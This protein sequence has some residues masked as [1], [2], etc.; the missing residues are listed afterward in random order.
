MSN[1]DEIVMKEIDKNV[2][3]KMGVA[4]AELH[5]SVTKQVLLDL[6]LLTP[7]E[8]KVGGKVKKAEGLQHE[9]TPT[10]LE[11]IVARLPLLLVG[12]AGCGKTHIAV[13]CAKM[14]DLAFYSI[15]VNEQ[16]SKAD[17]LG[18]KDANGKMV[19]TN[20]REAY[21]HGGVFIIDEIDAGNPNILTVINS[22]LSNDMCPFSD[23]MVQKHEDFVCVC[24]ANTFGEGESMQYIGRNILDSAT[25]DR[26]ATIHI[27]YSGLLE[28]ALLP[29]YFGFIRELRE[30]FNKNNIQFVV[31]TRGGLRLERM[32]AQIE[33]KLSAQQVV[34]CMNLHQH[35]LRDQK[36]KEVIQKYV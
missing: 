15:S 8:I 2:G 35:I 30:Y 21:E 9:M 29:N 14:L 27:D 3:E 6:K 32:R 16:T 31:S 33:K 24:T 20:F 10:V 36:V 23:G 19:R 28:K 26:F 34:D 1:I 4:K 25:K 11:Y 18:Y 7:I 13:H 22:A 5:T 17:F 12:Q